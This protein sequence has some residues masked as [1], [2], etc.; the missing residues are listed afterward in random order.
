VGMVTYRPATEADVG[1]LVAWHADPDVA[2]YWDGETFTE[3]EMRARLGRADVDMWIVEVDG[4]PVGHLQSWWEPVAPRRGGLD[5]FLV[6][7]ERGR[8]IMPQAA[9]LLARDLLAQGWS[10]V[11]V[12]PYAWNDRA[13]RA[14]RRAGFAEVSRHPPDDEHA[15]EWVLMRFVG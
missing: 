2:R 14:W 7:S 8:G 11:T 4:R 6:P 15:A 9:R 5:G 10:E 1:R 13:I 12:D 3:E